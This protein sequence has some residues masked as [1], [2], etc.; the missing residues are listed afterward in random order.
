MSFTTILHQAKSEYA[1]AYDENT[2]HLRL[3]TTKG[4]VQRVE[5]L[6]LDPFNWIPRNDGSMIYDLDK[7][8]I[9]R[10]AMEKEQVTEEYDCWFAEIGNQD[11]KRCKYCFL[12][13]EDGKEFIVGCHDKMPYADNKEELYNLFNYYNYPY[14]NEEDLY[15]APAW[16]ENTVWYQIFPE[17]FCN[18]TPNDGRDV[19][20]WGSE[21]LDGALK[22]F[23]GNLEG[24]IQKLDYIQ[25]M[26]FT[27]I[28]MTPIF[29]SPSSHKY[30]TTDYFKVDPEFGDNETLGRLVEEAHKRG[31]RVM[32]D[33]VFNHCGYQH[34]FW[35]DVLKKG[36]DSEYY[37]C[38]YVLDES[39]P[40]FDGEIVDGLPQE[41]PRERLKYRTFAYTPAMPKWNTGNPKVRNYLMD[42]ACYWVEQYHIDGWRLD[43]SNEV[44]HDFWREFRK[45]IKAVNSDVYILGENW[46]NSLPWLQG[47]QFDAVMN[48]EFAM[49]VWNYFK[50]DEKGSFIYAAKEFR[51]GVSK[52]LTSYPRHVARNMFNLLESHDTERILNRTN[53][54]IE[55]AKLAYIFLFTFPGAP[56]VYYGG[57]IG[58]RG[59]EHSNRQCMIWDPK[60][61]NQEL[62]QFVREM[63]ELRKNHDSFRSAQFQWL[64]QEGTEECLFFKKTGEKEMLYVFM[65]K[66]GEKHRYPVPLELRGRECVDCICKEK[67]FLGETFE[68]NRNGY[69]MYLLTDFGQ[70]S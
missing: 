32:L 20:E 55:M 2:L 31:I 40:V 17:R 47:D 25:K 1:Y 42:A 14:I 54:D 10:S 62:S 18:G 59:G 69:Q 64:N 23:G 63:I 26:G 57:E 28:Y 11:S 35:Q 60:E 45:R 53:G 13:E 66:E 49:P 29:E 6:A 21:E 51:N 36:K 61:Q 65:Q 34:P 52:V 27:G 37:D 8:S 16:V 48:Y 12:V 5:V 15:K 24:I 68:L 39:M 4:K 56:C 33:A 30:D 50:K 3:K 43:V 67:V 7:K 38:F 58:M 46:D 22:K 19:L 41:V 44:S 9:I 70:E